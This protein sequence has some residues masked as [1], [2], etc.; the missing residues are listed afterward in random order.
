MNAEIKN[1]LAETDALLASIAAKTEK[2]NLSPVGS[3]EAEC[4]MADEALNPTATEIAD[5]LN[6]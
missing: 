4:D 2:L 5:E 6:F 3:V 1:L